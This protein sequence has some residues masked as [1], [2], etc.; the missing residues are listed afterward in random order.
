MSDS[1]E[2]L[3]ADCEDTTVTVG[4]VIAALDGRLICGTCKLKLDKN[5]VPSIG[6]CN[7]MY[8][9]KCPKE[10]KS[11]NIIEMMFCRLVHCFQTVIKPGP[12]SKKMP[13]SDRL[14]AVKGRFIH[15]P[16]NAEQSFNQLNQTSKKSR[17]L[18]DIEDYVLVYGMP[19][20][21]KK[22]WK[23]IVDRS[24]VY[25]ALK[26]LIEINPNYREIELPEREEDFLPDVFGAES[27]GD[28]A[29]C[30]NDNDTAGGSNGAFSCQYCVT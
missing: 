4:D 26:V 1:D 13:A 28:I 9:G 15:L 27:D 17:S 20:K 2:D 12:V 25:S 30:G 16:L 5:Q 19:K 10:L 29:D 11:L 22:I 24:K 23:F 14:E 18:A 6:I 8:T 7:D 3:F 21:D